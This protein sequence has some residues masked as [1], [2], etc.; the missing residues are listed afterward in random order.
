MGSH[1]LL[2]AIY[3]TLGSN[4]HL[5][6]CRLILYSLSHQGSPNG[7][8]EKLP[9][10]SPGTAFKSDGSGFLCHWFEFADLGTDLLI[11]ELRREVSFK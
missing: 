1:S 7:V 10:N 9:T 4:L 6:N 8:F 2:Q 11:E 3:L 5:L